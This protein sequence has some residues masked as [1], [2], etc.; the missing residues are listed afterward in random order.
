MFRV[1]LTGCEKLS[2][3]EIKGFGG[4]KK[5]ECIHGKHK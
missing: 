1:T 5:E 4:G 2:T 3:K